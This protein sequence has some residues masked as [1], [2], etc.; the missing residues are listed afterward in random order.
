MFL[1]QVLTIVN[2]EICDGL[3]HDFIKTNHWY[4][5]PNMQ[6]YGE[7]VHITAWTACKRKIKVV[8]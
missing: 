5:N 8:V 3:Y 6:K 1:H 4:V 2:Q 7:R